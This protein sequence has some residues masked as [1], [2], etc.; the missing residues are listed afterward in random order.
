M[1]KNGRL[2]G[3]NEEPA[4]TQTVPLRARVQ[5]NTVKAT[6]FLV[7]TAGKRTS[8]IAAG[9]SVEHKM[10]ASESY[11]DD[12]TSDC[13]DVFSVDSRGRKKPIKGSSIFFKDV[14]RNLGNTPF[15]A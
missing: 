6:A 15:P 13:V 11:K 12:R 7:G 14:T 10:A 8:S 3:G 5:N 1:K 9:I 2:S 4:S